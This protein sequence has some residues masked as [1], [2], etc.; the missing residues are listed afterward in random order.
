MKDDDE[1]L[2]ECREVSSGEERMK[3]GG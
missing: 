3:R 2:Q 1:K